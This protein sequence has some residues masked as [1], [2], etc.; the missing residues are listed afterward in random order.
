[1]FFSLPATDFAPTAFKSIHP[2]KEL[3]SKRKQGLELQIGRLLG[4]EGNGFCQAILRARALSLTYHGGP[5]YGLTWELK[6]YFVSGHSD[7]SAKILFHSNPLSFFGLDNLCIYTHLGQSH[8]YFG[9]S[10]PASYS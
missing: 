3:E 10:H 8:L 9:Y 2:K 6:T 7:T 1:M 4:K 5:R